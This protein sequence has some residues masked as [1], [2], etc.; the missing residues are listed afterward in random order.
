M[1]YQAIKPISSSQWSLCLYSDCKW[2]T[3]QTSAG[4][5]CKCGSHLAYSYLKSSITQEL[6]ISRFTHKY[7]ALSLG[8]H[9]FPSHPF[10]SGWN[11]EKFPTNALAVCV[12]RMAFLIFLPLYPIK[13]RNT[14]YKNTKLSQR[15]PT[16]SHSFIHTSKLQS[17]NSL[18]TS[19][20]LTSS[21]FNPTS[22]PLQNSPMFQKSGI[23]FYIQD[24]VL[25]YICSPHDLLK[26][27]QC[28][29]CATSRR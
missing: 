22:S 18:L 24:L 14:V 29:S 15:M 4:Y 13:N 21:L 19:P 1:L 2:L 11:S 17:P 5:K 3:C 7:L 20:H 16:F 10:H 25:M 28:L 6:R 12:Q 27:I 8:Y 9:K 23:F 26:E